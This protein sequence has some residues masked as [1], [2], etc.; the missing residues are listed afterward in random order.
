MLLLAEDD[1]ILKYTDYLAQRNFLTVPAPVTLELIAA[2]LGLLSKS[3]DLLDLLLSRC[4]HGI[5]HLLSVCPLTGHIIFQ[6]RLYVDDVF[7]QQ[8]DDDSFPVSDLVF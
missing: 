2:D 6:S 8:V 4:K 5:E 1:N 3:G 7:R